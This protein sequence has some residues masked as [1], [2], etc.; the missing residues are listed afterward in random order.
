MAF[1]DDLT[2]HLSSALH[3]K[4][5][6]SSV[7]Y[8][9]VMLSNGSADVHECV[10]FFG[11]KNGDSY[12]TL[13]AK[14]P[15][16]P[17]DEWVIRVEY[18]RL[19]EICDLIGMPDAEQHL[20]QPISYTS[21]HGQPVMVTSYVRGENLLRATGK[22]IW[23][24]PEQVRILA[25]DVAKSL[26]HIMDRTARQLTDNDRPSSD[27]QKKADKFKQMHSLTENE[28]YVV[29]NLVKEIVDNELKASHKI[30]LQGDFWHGNMIRGEEYGKLVFI[31][32]QYARWATDASL[33]VYLFLLASSLATVPR[34]MSV[35]ER[36][37]GAAE[38][39]ATWRDNV[40]P[41]YLSAFGETDRY[42][43]L[44]PRSGMLMC[45]IEK[46]VR[47]SMD[48]GVDQENDL[49]WRFLFAELIKMKELA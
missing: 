43:L 3:H 34:N 9:W 33:D 14:I 22:K 41:S 47:A 15:R 28:L 16:L 5:G 48:L 21:L 46:A 40:I 44:S 7:A 2:T 11:F 24:K 20:P 38:T 23:Q 39:L 19:V 8:Y 10:V 13:V 25:M 31:D 30:L 12:P 6:L 18:E 35:I 36:A 27:I 4:H 26:H 37:R 32:W 45:C 29:E 49:I 17:E 1:V 42:S